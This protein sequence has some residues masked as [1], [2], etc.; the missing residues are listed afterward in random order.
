M[1]RRPPVAAVRMVGSGLLENLTSLRLGG[2]S[3]EQMK[4]SEL[5]P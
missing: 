4:S 2:G 1:E 3:S 5:Q